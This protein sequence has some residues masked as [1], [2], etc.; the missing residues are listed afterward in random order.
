[1]TTD[2]HDAPRITLLRHGHAVDHCPSGDFERALDDRGQSELERTALELQALPRLPTLVLASPA[3]RTR[4][5]AAVLQRVWARC[6][7][8]ERDPAPAVQVELRFE[9]KLYLAS[10][11]TLQ[12]I[13]ALHAPLQ[14]HLLIVGHN[15]GLS[16]LLQQFDVSRALGTGDWHSLSRL[17]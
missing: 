5:S 9:P 8:S 15:P 6:A 16:D 17:G 7:A 4:E 13:I 11:E 1:M 14:P 10:A 2:T 12:A 3:R